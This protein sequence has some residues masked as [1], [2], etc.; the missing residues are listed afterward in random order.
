MSNSHRGV[1]LSHPATRLT[2]GLGRVA[3]RT[4]R[5]SLRPL[6]RLS[7]AVALRAMTRLLR[8]SSADT[9][10]LR[11]SVAEGDHVYGLSDLDLYAVVTDRARIERRVR[12]FARV[13][14]T[15]ARFAH[16]SVYDAAELLDAVSTTVLTTPRAIFHDQ[17]RHHYSL[18]TRPGV[19]EPLAHWRLLAGPE[20]RPRLPACDRDAQLVAAWLELQCWWRHAAWACADGDATLGA[21]VC[22]KLVAEPLRTWLWLF[23]DEVPPNR[24]ATLERAVELLPEDEP[25]ARFA[26]DLRTRLAHIREAPFDE[27]LPW[28]VGL[29][30]RVARRIEEEL[31]KRARATEVRLVGAGEG[32]Q[33]VDWRALVLGELARIQVMDGSPG[34]SADLVRCAAEARE[35]VEPA[36]RAD[37][38]LVLPN[39]DV[40][41]RP[42]PPGALRSVQCALT[43]PVSF[44]LLEGRETAWFPDVA[45]WSAQDWAR[46]AVDE[47][48]AAGRSDSAAS[49]AEHFARTLEEGRPELLVT[50][51]AVSPRR[52]SAA[53]R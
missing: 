38:L 40:N 25:M 3:L 2:Y 51:A 7:Y 28:L 26:L 6:W 42:L 13:S 43:D 49:R 37:G 29:T 5:G 22:L 4:E 12:R 53:R 18:R 17:Q 16:S 52:D 20:R 47:H 36:L 19:G 33:L 11:G 27:V 39:G 9:V 50:E 14:P 35:G 8:S 15:L 21:S 34:N 41:G 1:I 44:A 45:G 48:R 10:Y 32:T 31:G 30:Q 23:H 24:T 46:R